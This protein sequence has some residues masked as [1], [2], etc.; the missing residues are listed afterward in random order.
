MSAKDIAK[1]LD[2]V[3]KN[4]QASVAEL[5]YLAMKEAEGIAKSFAPWTDR[6]THARNSIYGN[7]YK[8]GDTILGLL[9]IGMS[10]GIFLELSNDKQYAIIHPTAIITR[11]FVKQKLPKIKLKK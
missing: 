5:M 7:S 1:N 9:G 11:A 2:R 8:F 4:R 6:T 10:Y 3:R